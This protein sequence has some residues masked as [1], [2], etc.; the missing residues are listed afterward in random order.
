VAADRLGFVEA[1]IAERASRSD[2]RTSDILSAANVFIG[3]AGAL[4]TRIRLGTGIRPLP[5][6]HPYTVATEAAVC[7]HMTG[8]RFMLGYGGTHSGEGGDHHVQIGIRSEDQ[9]G[10]VYEAVDFIVKCFTCPEPFDFDGKFWQG[11][12]IHIMP[13]PLQQ[14][15]PP[16]AAACSGA[17]ETLEVAGSHGFI[18]LLGRGLDAPA[19]IREMGDGYVRAALEAGRTPERRQFR[20]AHHVYVSRTRQQAEAELRDGMV[21]WIERRRSI[22]DFN[23]LMRWLEPEQTASTYFDYLLDAG[24]L[25]AGDPDAMCETLEDYYRASGGFGVLLIFAAQGYVSLEQ[26]K[27]SLHLIADQVAPRLRHLDPD[28]DAIS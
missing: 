3:A 2:R 21:P 9:R 13:R 28:R 24:Y 25:W 1:W 10:M 26:W 23:G 11:R 7:D 18:P 27:R 22:H 16:I 14:P 4:T 15:H 5:Y 12:N 20:V 17:V 6:Y 8:G 19:A